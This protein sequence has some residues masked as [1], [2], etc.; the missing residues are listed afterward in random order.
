MT[1]VLTASIPGLALG[2]VIAACAAAA[3]LTEDERLPGFGAGALA[4]LAALI[5][6]RWST[7]PAVITVPA[8]AALTG[9][10]GAV[11]GM[12]DLLLRRRQDAG[13]IV[14]PV[15][16]LRQVA[17]LALLLGLAAIAQ[18]P[19]AV[20]LPVGPLGGT[21]RTV[22]ALIAVLLGLAALYALTRPGV[23]VLPLAVRWAV[24]GAA[25]AIV[26]IPA[27]GL[28]NAQRLDPSNIG[29]PAAIAAGVADPF[30]LAVRA[31]AVALAGG[32]APSRILLWS[33][34]LAGGEVALR[35]V[36]AGLALLPVTVIL[37]LGIATRVRTAGA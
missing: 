3:W 9:A 4:G 28:L 10:A 7:Q 29:V 8:V 36:G 30:G 21:P 1:G 12:S 35:S 20:E 25:V 6:A 31:L 33:A 14:P 16:L 15:S 34:L 23:S 11:A 5:A 32:S 22:P 37:A 19:F 17:V 27:A 2:A 24:A 18:P 26:T 13:G